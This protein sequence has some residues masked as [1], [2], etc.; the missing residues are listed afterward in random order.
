MLQQAPVQALPPL[1]KLQPHCAPVLHEHRIRELPC[2]RTACSTCSSPCRA[3]T[4][5]KLPSIPGTASSAYRVR[6]CCCL[7]TPCS[8][9][10][11]D[12][13]RIFLSRRTACS[14]AAASGARRRRCRRTLCSGF[15]VCRGGRYRAERNE[16]LLS[17]PQPPRPSPPSPTPPLA[18]QRPSAARPPARRVPESTWRRATSPRLR[19]L[20][21]RANQARCSPCRVA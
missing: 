4:R 3:R 19:Q 6:K 5:R 2:C 1:R 18:P 10:C 12:R 14:N 21:P 8:R 20:L 7:D 15:V 9:S 16:A 17:Y 11:G 13:A